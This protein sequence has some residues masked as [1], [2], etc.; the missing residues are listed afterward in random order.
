MP[1]HVGSI[2]LIFRLRHMVVVRTKADLEI[3]FNGA[4]SL[5]IRVGPEYQHQL[6]GICGNFNGDATDDKVLLSGEKDLS[7]AEFGNAWI[8]NTS[9][10][11]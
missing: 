2:A 8:S 5:F 11:W 4:S 6:C 3:Q 7:D 9:P 1:A 10:K